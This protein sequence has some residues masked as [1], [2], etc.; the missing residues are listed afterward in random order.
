MKTALTVVIVAASATLGAQ[1]LPAFDALSVKR[2]TAVNE[3]GAISPPLPGQFRIVNVPLHFILHDALGVREHELIGS[4]DWA[5]S[6]AYDIVGRYPA[7]AV[8]HAAYKQMVEKALVERFGLKTHRETREMPVYRLVMAR[9]D[10]QLGPRLT[11]SAVDCEQWFAEKKPQ[12]GAGSPS[13][14]APGGRRMACAMMAQRRQIVG[15]TQPISRLTRSLE[16]MVGRFVIDDTGLT[17]NYDIDL[18]FAPTIEAGGNPAAA[19]GAPSIF[20]ALQEQL[21]L[22]L[23]ADRR[24]MG[25]VVIDAIDRPTPD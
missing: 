16:S 3:S 13:A 23:D 6:E 25:V 15:G 14:L 8:P 1:A 18:E 5:R 21:G 24:P 19:D 7:D 22:K 12:L 11:A 17:G 20:T 2:N 4:P 9:P 10:R